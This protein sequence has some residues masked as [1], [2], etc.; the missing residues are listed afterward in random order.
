MSLN[1]AE[2]LAN[3]Y[4]DMGKGFKAI[5]G[6]MNRIVKN[7][8]TFLGF[9]SDEF[10][11]DGARCLE[12]FGCNILFRWRFVIRNGTGYGVLGAWCVG[13]HMFEDSGNFY[14]IYFRCNGEVPVLQKT[15]EQKTG[16]FYGNQ[17][18]DMENLLAEI[19][20]AFLAGDRFRA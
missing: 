20:E 14:E 5:D 17:I 18:P 3:A 10:A 12:G 6:I 9:Q 7:A 1:A 4:A 11:D 19:I 8:G 15:L 16:D 13:P 2:S